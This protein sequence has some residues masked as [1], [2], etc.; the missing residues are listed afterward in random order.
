MTGRAGKRPRLRIA[1]IP[2]GPFVMNCTL[3]KDE[4]TGK[5]LVL[6]PGDEVERVAKGVEREGIEVVA[7]VGTHGHLDH[8]G[9]AA[10]LKEALGAPFYFHRDDRWLLENLESQGR[11]FG[12]GPLRAASVDRWLE[13]GDRVE[14]GSV[15]LEVIHAPGH[16]PGS[17]CLLGEGHL[18]A[19]DV[20]FRGSVGRT[21]L[22]GGDW[23]ALERSIR[24][25]LFPAGD[26]IVVHPGHG[27]ETTIGEE[28]RANPFV[29]EGARGERL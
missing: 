28:R 12:L 13:H 22:W 14:F 17:I 7:L 16:S 4:E 3:L 23:D 27:P 20:L 15:S 24:E 2:V 5:G 11:M 18:F 9:R 21:D 19:G 26:S 1:T 29:G 6:D 25:R 10:E 8:V